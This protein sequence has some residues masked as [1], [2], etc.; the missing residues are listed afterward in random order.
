MEASDEVSDEVNQRQE[1]LSQARSAV[2]ASQPASAF[3]QPESKQ[4]QAGVRAPRQTAVG[5][6]ASNVPMTRMR[7]A[8]GNSKENGGRVG[9]A[10]PRPSRRPGRRQRRRRGAAD[11]RGGAD[12][13]G[14]EPGQTR[15]AQDRRGSDG[16]RARA[17]LGGGGVPGDAGGGGRP[18][19]APDDLIGR[20][21]GVIGAAP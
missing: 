14:P 12:Q 1:V 5:S 18:R 19:G 15:G 13:A 3:S 11:A 10:Q 16:D 9:G 2:E 4:D 20:A 21:P 17:A 6:N 8:A 7:A